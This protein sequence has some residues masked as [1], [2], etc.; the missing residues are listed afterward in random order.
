MELSP[1]YLA[2]QV[3]V[4]TRSTPYAMRVADPLRYINV[5]DFCRGFEKVLDVGCSGFEPVMFGCTHAL[6]VH[7]IAGVL[8]RANGYKG[9]FVVGSADALPFPDKSFPCV[10]CS[11]VIEHLPELSAVEKTFEE[12]DRIGTS[13]LVTTPCKPIPEPTHRHLFLDAQV[14]KWCEKYGAEAVK[15]SLWWFIF[16]RADGWKPAL[17][18]KL[19]KW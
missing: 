15:V 4:I 10:V 12:V 17:D 18:D 7:P 8:L 19:L 14:A 6:D 2:E 11:E 5:K 16:K 13:W 3:D 1:D 9:E